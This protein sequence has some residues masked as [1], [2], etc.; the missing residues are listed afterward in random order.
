[1]GVSSGAR[2]T[3]RQ[4]RR[5]RAAASSS[6]RWCIR[7]ALRGH[8]V[9]PSAAGVEEPVRVI[10]RCRRKSSRFRPLYVSYTTREWLTTPKSCLHR[11]SCRNFVIGPRVLA[12]RQ[13]STC[14]R[15]QVP[16]CTPS[17]GIFVLAR[18]Q[19]IIRQDSSSITVPGVERGVVQILALGIEAIRLVLLNGIHCA[20]R[21]GK[22]E[23][24]TRRQEMSSPRTKALVLF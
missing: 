11:A 4:A 10:T 8:L 6:R 15:R 23:A 12:H 9:P 5:A 21:T 19:S 24:G 2:G 18:M 20:S 13:P 1:M 14:S 22:G 17:K 3:T 7:D 16:S